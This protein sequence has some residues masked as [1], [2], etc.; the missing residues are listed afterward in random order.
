MRKPFRM[1]AWNREAF[2]RLVDATEEAIRN[3]APAVTVKLDRK[4]EITLDTAE[5]FAIVQEVGEQFK[6]NPQPTFPENKEGLE[7]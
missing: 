2:D 1:I 5:A 3:H 7:P 6:R 4:T